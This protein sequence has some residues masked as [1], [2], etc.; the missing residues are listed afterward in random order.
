M[1]DLILNLECAI[2]SD[3]K[4]VCEEAVRLSNKLS[5]NVAFDFND[6]HMFATP[7]TTAKE[8]VNTYYNKSN[9]N[10]KRVSL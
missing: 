9:P 8:L 5:I 6:K 3:I 7:S 10:M 2:C 1:S 4:D